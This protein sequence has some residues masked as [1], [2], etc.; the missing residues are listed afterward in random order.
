MYDIRNL[1]IWKTENE[2]R[3]DDALAI[4]IAELCLSVRSYNCLRRAGCRTVGDVVNLIENDE[5]GLRGIRNLGIRSEEEILRSVEHFR[6]QVRR[7]VRAAENDTP[8]RRTLIRPAKRLWD[9]DIEAFGIS[10]YAL[11]RLRKS[12]IRKV[13][14]LYATDPHNEPGWYAVRELFEKIPMT[15]K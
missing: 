2:T 14:D 5:K 13:K 3:P 11:T 1:N 12:G 10:E 6:E 8:V 4:D 7:P 15:G 9:M